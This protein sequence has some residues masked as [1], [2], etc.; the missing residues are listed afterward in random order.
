MT[1]D[2]LVSVWYVGTEE[3]FDSLKLTPSGTIYDWQPTSCCLASR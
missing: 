2:G 3:H 1:E